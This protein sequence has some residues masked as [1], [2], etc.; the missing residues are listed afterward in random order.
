MKKFLKT[1]LSI[2][3]ACALLGILLWIFVFNTENPFYE[4]KL[5]VPVSIINEQTLQE[6]DLVLKSVI[7]SSVD[8]YVR[9]RSDTVYKVTGNDFKLVLD[10]SNINTVND[11]RILLPAP[12]FSN[13][14]IYIEKMDKEYFDIELERIITKIFPVEVK[15]TGVPKDGYQIIDYVVSP[16]SFTLEGLESVISSVGK[17]EAVLDVES[18]DGS[19]D[20]ERACKV[21]DAK[22]ETI[23]EFDG[24][25]TGIQLNIAKE[26]PVTVLTQGVPEAEYYMTSKSAMPKTLLVT[27]LNT[28]L[29]AITELLTEP[30]DITGATSEVIVDTTVKIPEGVELVGDTNMVSATISMEKLIEMEWNMGANSVQLQNTDVAHN[31]NYQVLNDVIGV[32]IKGRSSVISKLKQSDLLI[33]A[34]VRGLPEGLH[35]V[36]PKVVIPG[37]YSYISSETVQIKIDSLASVTLLPADIAVN[38]K[39]AAFSYSIKESSLNIV[40]QGYSKDLSNITA[41]TL[42]AYVEGASLGVGTHTVKV[43]VSLPYGVAVVG[44]TD[45][46]LMVTVIENP[47]P[48]VNG[49]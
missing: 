48:T 33:Y 38:N 44:N 11:T 36:K 13:K 39:N 10:L 46:L 32:K 18:L 22:E 8:I 29:S 25:T 2:K 47:E 12:Q 34:D 3:I 28:Q 21:Y 41:G 35:G 30:V 6:K 37:D 49:G 5:A 15:I 20:E 43:T 7:P 16:A 9:G 27:G 26:V 45:V 14:D 42:K 31:Y 17:I 4:V 1:N 23:A 40:L 24:L 19:I